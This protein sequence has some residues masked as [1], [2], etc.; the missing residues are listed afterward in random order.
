MRV[1][2]FGLGQYFRNRE[3]KILDALCN[4]EI[5]AYMDNDSNCVGK[6]KYLPFYTPEKCNDLSFDIIIVT[7]TYYLDIK[8]SLLLHNIQEEKIIPWEKFSCYRKKDELIVHECGI[9]VKS[10]V[11]IV[12]S[13]LGF[14][15]APMA[16]YS[17]A[18]VLKKMGYGVAILSEQ[19]DE[20]YVLNA[21]KKGIDILVYPRLAYF[22][23]K[24]VDVTEFDHVIVNTVI[25]INAVYTISKVRN[26]IWWIHEGK[27]EYTGNYRRSKFLI[28]DVKESDWMQRVSIYA[29]SGVAR[30]NFIEF[31]PDVSVGIWTLGIPDKMQVKSKEIKTS[32]LTIAI[33]GGVSSLKGHD[34]L[35]NALCMMKEKYRNRY[36]VLI[37]GKNNNS[38]FERKFLTE[39]KMISRIKLIGEMTNEELY[40]AYPKIN[41][42]VCASREETL[43]L[44]IVE[45]M[46]F[47]KICVTT[48]ATGISKYIK[49]RENGFVVPAGD[50]FSLKQCLEYIETHKKECIKIADNGRKTYEKYFSMDAFED[51]TR[52]VIENGESISL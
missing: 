7:S 34:V 11:L 8:Q 39:T 19:A 46:M 25:M 18:L 24:E 48:D 2:I 27:D 49:N 51:R 17:L 6:Y 37:I 43:S 45:A 3:E 1:V 40:K 26:V 9:E 16:V 35:F 20:N 23:P 47:G 4:D 22:F 12:S 50:A 41:V 28:A 36:Q 5:V 44:V 30:N 32:L 15:G 14:D 10:K 21:K 52:A 31:Y 42:V 29:I 33:I 13:E 38:E